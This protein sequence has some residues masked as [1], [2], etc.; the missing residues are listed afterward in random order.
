MPE[1]H[2]HGDDD[3]RRLRH[4]LRGAYNELR[5]CVEVLRHEAAGAEALEWLALVERAAER[6][7]EAVV[8]F[9]RFVADA[10]GGESGPTS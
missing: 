9:E 7:D 10:P 8:R 2:G 5:L 4:D 3:L 1:T 6:C